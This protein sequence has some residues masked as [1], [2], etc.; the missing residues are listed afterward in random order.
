MSRMSYIKI[1]AHDVIF[2]IYIK[3]KKPYVITA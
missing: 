1:V 2:F 3:Y